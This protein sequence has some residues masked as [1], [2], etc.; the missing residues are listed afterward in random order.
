MSGDRD[1]VFERA[2]GR[3]ALVISLPHV[4]TG[5]PPELAERMTPRARHVEDTD[6]HV[7]HLYRFAR[8]AGAAWLEAR[9]SRYVIDLNRPPGD[10]PLYPGQASTGLCPT[11]TFAGE[12]LYPGSPPTAT[13]VGAR[14]ERYWVPYH[15][16]L[17]ELLAA[18]RT[19]HGFAVLL[20]GHSIRSVVPR[21]F[22]GRLPDVN[23]GTH[24]GRSCDPRLATG[25]VTRLAAQ[26]DFTHVLNG[27][28]K[29]GYI[30]RA[31]GQPA[32]GVH[33]VQ[34]E[35]AQAAYM[36]ESGTAFD[37]RRAEPLRDLLR[38]LV[39]ALLEFRPRHAAPS[40]AL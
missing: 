17:G 39:A 24:D 20:D 33:A 12:A 30:T 27:R 25:L 10:E 37:D 23:L 3:S 35:L 26:R 22:P 29:G 40:G 11:A 7:Q 5:I 31:Y 15:A 34:I 21:L 13:E 36:D 32:A 9:L 28:F 6:W 2:P 14:R 4:G 8:A 38:V 19:R 16:A 18:A 1:A